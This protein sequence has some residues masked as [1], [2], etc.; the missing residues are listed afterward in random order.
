MDVR[1]QEQLSNIRIGHR[2]LLES[3]ACTA[4]PQKTRSSA[5]WPYSSL[6]WPRRIMEKPTE[7]QIRQRAHEIWERHHRPDG[8]DDE[9]WHQAEQELLN[10]SGQGDNKGNFD[11]P[12]VLPG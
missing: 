4:L 6:Q 9:F 1:P 5:G 10:E 7:D 2:A 3:M 8:R 12:D 11:T